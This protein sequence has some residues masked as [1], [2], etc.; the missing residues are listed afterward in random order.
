[1]LYELCSLFSGGGGLRSSPR[2]L[3]LPLCRGGG[4]ETPAPAVASAFLYGLEGLAVLRAIALDDTG[5]ATWRWPLLL[6]LGETILTG[7]AD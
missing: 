5:C 6:L 4:E 1:M 2:T 7:G 3:P